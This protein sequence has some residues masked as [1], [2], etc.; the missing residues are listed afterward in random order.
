MHRPEVQGV[1]GVILHLI[2]LHCVEGEICNAPRRELVLSEVRIGFS[3][4]YG[5][6]EVIIGVKRPQSHREGESIHHMPFVFHVIH[7]D[8]TLRECGIA[9]API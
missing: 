8:S 9:R 2:A 1:P 5:V 4:R 3:L 6:V 7:Y